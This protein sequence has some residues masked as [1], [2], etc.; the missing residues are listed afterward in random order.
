MVS[1]SWDTRIRPFFS[2]VFDNS[3]VFRSVGNNADNF[4][5]L[6]GPQRGKFIDI[7]DNNTEK[8]TW[9]EIGAVFRLVC[10]QRGK[11]IG[12]V[13]NNVEHFSALWAP[14]QKNF[15]RC[16]Q[17]IRR[18][19]GSTW[20]KKSTSNSLGTVPVCYDLFYRFICVRFSWFFK[21]KISVSF[22]LFPKPDRTENYCVW[23]RFRPKPPY[24]FG[25]VFQ[26]TILFSP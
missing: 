11:M 10:L 26:S 17:W 15:R 20:C 13:G 1:N 18:P 3:A 2:V 25:S 19:D 9:T 24:H 14:T 8:H 22:D 21:R 7:V 4:S 23:I 16:S 12:V 6:C 5:A